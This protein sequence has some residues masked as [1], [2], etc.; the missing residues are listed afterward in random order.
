LHI[1]SSQA[2]GRYSELSAIT[3]TKVV[4]TI[5]HI[6]M[7]MVILKRLSIPTV[8]EVLEYEINHLDVHVVNGLSPH[9]VQMDVDPMRPT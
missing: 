5:R 2:H 4:V 7:R 1:V 9:F 6:G 8:T 3:W